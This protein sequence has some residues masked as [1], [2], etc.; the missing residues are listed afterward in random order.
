MAED[1][2][3]MS[4]VAFRYFVPSSMVLFLSRPASIDSEGF[5]SVVSRCESAFLCRSDGSTFGQIAIT[6]PQA[7]AFRD[8]FGQ[9]MTIIR[10]F[11]L[12]LFEHDYMNHLRALRA[13]LGSFTPDTDYDAVTIQTIR[14][15]Q[16]GRNIAQRGT[17]SNR[18]G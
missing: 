5:I 17:R 3:Y 13:W 18:R 1:I 15:R 16:F 7:D 6:R 11:D 10:E 12:G 9:L 8:W 2:T 14:Q 4:S